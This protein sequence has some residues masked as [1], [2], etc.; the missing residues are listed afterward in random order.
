MAPVGKPLGAPRGVLDRF[1]DAQ[2]VLVEGRARRG[3]LHLPGGT[4]EQLGTELGLQ[5]AD[6]LRKRG[7]RHVQPRGRPAE[8]A[9]LGDGDEVTQMSQLHRRTSC[10]VAAA[11]APSVQ[12]SVGPL[13]SSNKYS[14]AIDWYATDISGA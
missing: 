12:P 2:R 4:G 10:H 1:Q 14:F 11:T 5:L 7:L 9:G 3:Q 13:F 8:V 6:R